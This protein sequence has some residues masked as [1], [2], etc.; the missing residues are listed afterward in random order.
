MI[1]FLYLT[2]FFLISCGTLSQKTLESKV[3]EAKFHFI[4]ER[5]VSS[6]ADANNYM[7][8]QLNYLNLLYQQSR[9]P[10]YGQYKWSE[11]CL[12]VTKI[13]SVEVKEKYLLSV[14]DLYM[15]DEGDFGHCPENK[16]AKRAYFILLYCM[17]KKEVVYDIRVQ[18]D[19][20]FDFEKLDLC[21]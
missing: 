16:M 17:N 8:N 4:K 13:G 2:L 1:K 11:Y 6:V 19:T 15:N 3:R 7:Q 10:Y 18:F 21:P 20:Q 14:S 9:D 5:P 12:N